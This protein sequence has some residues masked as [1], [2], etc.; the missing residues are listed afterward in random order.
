MQ[1]KKLLKVN[2]TTVDDGKKEVVKVVVTPFR[3][4]TRLCCRHEAQCLAKLAELGFRNAPKLISST[5][6]SF[7][8][9]KV[10]GTHLRG[11]QPIDEQVFLRIMEVVREL[12][13]LGFAHGNLRP[14]N[15]VIRQDKEPVLID[16]ETCCQRIS[17]LFHF[18]R[19]RDHLRMYWLWQSRVVRSNPEMVR[20]RFPRYVVW[21][22]FVIA[23]ITRFGGVYTSVR[24]WLKKSLRTK[25]R[26]TPKS[27]SMPLREDQRRD[28]SMRR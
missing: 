3:W 24:R 4:L 26:G 23:P 11:H 27:D 17:P 25:R 9:E 6:N 1:I 7:T 22:M 15:I 10:E 16:F 14:N 28:A 19:F 5:A 12:H 21:A 2:H 8:M 13:E 18:A 20:A